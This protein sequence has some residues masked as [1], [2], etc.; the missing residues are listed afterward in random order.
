MHLPDD[1][2]NVFLRI[3]SKKRIFTTFMDIGVVH[4]RPDFERAKEGRH[5]P[6]F[7]VGHTVLP[8]GFLLVGDPNLFPTNY[9]L[10]CVH[11]QQIL[12]F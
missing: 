4:I 9:T 7:V 2:L 6:Q 5:T 11:R 10:G 3:S 1:P 8:L 12:V